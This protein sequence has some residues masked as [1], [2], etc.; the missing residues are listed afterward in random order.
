MPL[1][2]H[3][4][5]SANVWKILVQPGDPVTPDEPLMILES[6]KMEIPVVSDEGGTLVR[7]H[8]SEGEN[9]NPGQPLLDIAVD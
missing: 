4:E 9:V 3:A 7:V 2:L 1:T 8:V 5:L 6:M